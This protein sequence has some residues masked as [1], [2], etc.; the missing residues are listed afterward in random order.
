LPVIVYHISY[1]VLARL[2][3]SFE[4]IIT[5]FFALALSLS[6]RLFISSLQPLALPLEITQRARDKTS[7]QGKA[8]SP[9]QAL[10]RKWFRLILSSCP[11]PC[12]PAIRWHRLVALQEV[13]S[14]HLYSS[15]TE[16][17][18][19]I[20]TNSFCLCL[21]KYVCSAVVRGNPLTFL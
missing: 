16:P 12:R 2:P 21:L 10:S 6:L 9:K 15:K 17:K 7:K 19:Y 14:S 18:P 3:L 11:E 13:L 5:L 8:L 1:S 4:I 20:K